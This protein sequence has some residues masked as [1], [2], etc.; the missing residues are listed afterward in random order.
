VELNPRS[1]TVVLHKQSLPEIFVIS[2]N[3]AGFN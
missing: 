3:E 2:S 1:E